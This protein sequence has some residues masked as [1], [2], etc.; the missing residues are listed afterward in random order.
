MTSG[1]ILHPPLSIICHDTTTAYVS[2]TVWQAIT[3]FT[4]GV[5]LLPARHQENGRQGLITNLIV[6]ED[7]GRITVPWNVCHQFGL[8]VM[9]RLKGMEE[10]TVNF[11]F[12][13]TVHLCL[14]KVDGL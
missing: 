14:Y 5:L 2:T 12:S 11:K 4:L 7:W 10:E 13:Y 1:Q 9:L 6:S 8:V 3:G